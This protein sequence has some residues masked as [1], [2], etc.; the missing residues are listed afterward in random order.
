MRRYS[1]GEEIDTVI[2]SIDSDR[3]R[4]SLGIKQL[5]LD[6]FADY[7][8]EH[9]RGSVVQGEVVAVEPKEATIRLAAEV[10]G[11]LRAA[12]MAVERVDDARSA[13]SLGD[14]VTAKIIGIDRKSRT[15]NLS[16]KAR[17]KDEESQAHQDY[18]KQDT[19]TPGPTTLGTS[20]RSRWL[21]ATTNARIGQARE[22]PYPPP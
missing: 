3:E 6:P 9:P 19:A 11:R 1:K 21:T 10:D 16:I 7:I 12:E 4:I 8:S 2:L 5:D 22:T 17:T 20:S 15:I 18:R 13:F 14:E